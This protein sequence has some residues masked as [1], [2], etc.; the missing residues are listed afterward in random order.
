MTNITK[1]GLGNDLNKIILNSLLGK[2]KKCKDAGDFEI[3]LDDLFTL[4]EKIMI[5]KRLAIKLL[6]QNGKRNKEISRILDVSRATIDFVKRGFKK[7][8][9]K[10]K[11]RHNVSR[12]D[13]TEK[14][15][16]PRQTS[17][18]GKNRWD[19][20]NKPRI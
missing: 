8:F 19:F 13:Y 12:S 18:S 14:L 10:V 4:K 15:R 16:R 6:I 5:K 17:Y 7:P 11:I 1:R 3:I 2:I 20:L 9:S